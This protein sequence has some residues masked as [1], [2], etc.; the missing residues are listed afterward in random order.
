MIFAIGCQS[1]AEDPKPDQL[2]PISLTKAYPGSISKV[3]KVELLDGSTGERRT[4]VDQKTIQQWLNKIKNIELDP[5]DN[6]EGRVGYIFGIT[7]FENEKKTLGFIP[8][9]INNIY[10]K[11][12]EEFLKPIRAIFK[13]QFRRE[14]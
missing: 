1:N 10:Y 14:F 2:N 3:D 4:I 8:N 7:L 11:N 13:E 12:N 6:Q 9:E 5:D